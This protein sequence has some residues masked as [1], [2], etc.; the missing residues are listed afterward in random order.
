MGVRW[1]NTPAGVWGGDGLRR[2]ERTGEVPPCARSPGSAPWTTH[3]TAR[4]PPHQR[5]LT[6]VRP[7]LRVA[8]EQPVQHKVLAQRERVLPEELLVAGWTLAPGKRASP[9]Q[10]RGSAQQ[11]MNPA[12]SNVLTAKGPRLEE[13]ATVTNLLQCMSHRLR[14]QSPEQIFTSKN[15]EMKGVFFFTLWA[16]AIHRCYIYLSVSHFIS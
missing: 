7:L 3:R 9:W 12:P 2:E 16:G 4:P 5:S 10:P 11:R 15:K 14:E 13:A 6:Y 8:R 1:L